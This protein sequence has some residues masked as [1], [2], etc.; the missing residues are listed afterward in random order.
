MR[1]ELWRVLARHIDIPGA[2]VLPFGAGLVE[3]IEKARDVS[4]SKRGYSLPRD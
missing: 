1:I 4:K 2:A 3:A